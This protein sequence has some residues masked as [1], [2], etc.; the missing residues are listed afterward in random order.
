[1]FDTDKQAYF[2][3]PLG[4]IGLLSRKNTYVTLEQLN[5]LFPSADIN[6][7]QE[8]ADVYNEYCEQFNMHTP[9]IIAH[10]FAQIMEEVGQNISYKNESLNYSSEHLKRPKTIIVNGKK[11]PKGP[12]RYFIQNPTEADKYGRNSQH[13]AD[14]RAIANLAYANRNGNGDVA[15]NDGW[16]FR[17]KGFIQLTGRG[18]YNES[19]KEIE[20]YAPSSGIDIINNPESILT[21]KGAMLSSMGYWTSHGLNSIAEKGCSDADVNN[22]TNIVNYY[23]DSKAERRHNFSITKKVWK[24][25]E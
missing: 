2:I 12:F 24:C 20:K 1:Q 19:Q 6:K 17:G 5:I 16:N 15:S 14:Q 9:K 23:T 4:V 18:N 22:V 21:I 11:L 10:F 7:K 3:H 8:M 25:E 13:A